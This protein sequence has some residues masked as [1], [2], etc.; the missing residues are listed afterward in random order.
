[1]MGNNLEV[2]DMRADIAVL[3]IA[4]FSLLHPKH[5]CCIEQQRKSAM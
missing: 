5:P 1:M 4:L 2:I 3:S